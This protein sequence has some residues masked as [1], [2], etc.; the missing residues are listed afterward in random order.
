MIV[1]LF[2]VVCVSAALVT[3]TGVLLHRSSGGGLSEMFGG[4]AQAAARGSSNASRNLTRFT[5]A[6]LGVWTA[7]VVVLGLLHT[8]S[9]GI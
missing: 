1:T 7:S 4:S 3:V 8:G 2:N 6:A 5:L 9:A